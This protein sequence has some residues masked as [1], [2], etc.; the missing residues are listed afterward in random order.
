MTTFNPQQRRVIEANPTASFRDS[1]KRKFSGFRN[2]KPPKVKRW[3]HQ[4]DLEAAIGKQIGVTMTCGLSF[5]GELVA[6]DQFTIKL[7][8]VDHIGTSTLFKSAFA[9]YSVLE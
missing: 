6:A 8:L 2:N 1:E 5:T 3:S 4:D 9:F 7:R